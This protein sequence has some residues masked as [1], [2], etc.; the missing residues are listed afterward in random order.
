MEVPDGYLG[1]AEV[2][3]AAEVEPAKVTPLRARRE[4]GREVEVTLALTFPCA[5][6]AGDVLLVCE[7]QRSRHWAIGVISGRAPESLTFPGDVTLRA[8]GGTLN[9]R[10]DAGLELESPLLTLRGETLRT[11]AGS[12][13]ER[14]DTAY[15]WVRE[16][17]TVRAGESRRTVLGEDHSRSKR[18]VTLAE[19]TVKIDAHQVHLGH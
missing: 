7:D 8:V 18:S 3:S 13:T 14:A 1:P 16:L 11:F 10:G 5:P 19:G 2:V 15:R 12:L 9:L 4:D 17:L 6:V